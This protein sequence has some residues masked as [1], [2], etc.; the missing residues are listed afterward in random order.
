MPRPDA[1]PPEV[2]LRPM[3]AADVADGLRLCRAAGWNQLARDW[4]Q[5]LALTPDGARVAESGG[6]VVGTVATMRYG[7]RFGWIGMVLVDP[8]HRGHGIGTRLL[9]EGLSLLGDLPLA[10]LDA[11]PA[12]YPLYLR[13]GFVEE[14]RL[15]R[16]QAIVPEGLA[17]PAAIDPMAP[18]D[19]PEVAAL[20]EPA[21]GAGRAAMLRWMLEGAPQYAWVA[22][23]AG[24]LAGYVLGRR[25]H[26]F[27][28]L[29]PL[30]AP[31]VETARRLATACLRAHAGRAFVADVPE[32][33]TAWLQVLES[34]GF[35]ALRPLIRMSKGAAPV[36]RDRSQFAILGP[37]FG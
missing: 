26:D 11:T 4:E 23:S 2:S 22:R 21:F 20:D 7:A 12:G 35:R 16:M 32:H 24:R 33:A 19:L 9:D 31:D 36:P 3:R 28:H 5:F 37:E 1:R 8:A 18:A 17:V 29:G 15:Q 25:G 27:E 34:L 6:R 13:R 14:S 30:V 10:R